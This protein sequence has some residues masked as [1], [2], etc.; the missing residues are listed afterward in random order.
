M[1]SCGMFLF[2]LI[3][4]TGLLFLS[5]T[6]LLVKL[7]G[8]AMQKQRAEDAKLSPEERAEKKRER[9][10]TEDNR[11]K[12]DRVKEEIQLFILKRLKAPSTA[13]IKLESKESIDHKT[14]YVTGFV[15]SQNSFGAMLRSN[16]YA[17]FD[18]ETLKQ[19]EFDWDQP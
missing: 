17:K 16:V 5:C 4:G 18:A 8:D 6:A 14:I 13:T 3:V 11:K 9:Q 15:D 12:G 2:G 19:I 10:L 1:K 7:N